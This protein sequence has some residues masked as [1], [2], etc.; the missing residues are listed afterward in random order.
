MGKTAPILVIDNYDSFVHNLVR[1]LRELHVPVVVYRHDALDLEEIAALAP[2]GILLSPGPKRPSDSGICQAAVRAFAGIIP[3]LGVCLG[4]QVIADVFGGSI[5]K[6]KEPVHGKNSQIHHDGR[7]VFTA[8]PMPFSA[9]RYHSLV[10]SDIRFPDCLEV[11]ARTP[12]GIIMGIRHRTLAVE[13]VQFHPEAERTEHGHLLLANFIHQCGFAGEAGNVL[14]QNGQSANPVLIPQ[15]AKSMGLGLHESS[16]AILTDLDD[17]IPYIAETRIQLLSAHV[18]A[19]EVFTATRHMAGTVFLDSAARDPELGRYS[20]VAWSPWMALTERAGGTLRM[21]WDIKVMEPEF[22][23]KAEPHPILEPDPETMLLPEDVLT[24]VAR[25]L[26]ANRKAPYPGLPFVGGAIGL[27]G[28]EAQVQATGILQSEPG[29]DF[30]DALNPCSQIQPATWFWFHRNLFISDHATGLRYL[31][32]TGPDTDMETPESGEAAFWRMMGNTWSIPLDDGCLAVDMAKKP[33]SLSMPIG[34]QE[35]FQTNFTEEAYCDAVSAMRTHISNGDIYL[36]NMTRQFRTKTDLSGFELHDR[37]RRLNP[38]SFSAWFPFGRFELI[39]ASP[40][41]FLRI[42]DGWVETRPIK[43]TRP[44]GTTPE[45]DAANRKALGDSLKDQAELL[46][47]TDLERNDLSLVCEPGTVSVSDL[48]ELEVHPTVFHLA[49][50]VRGRLENGLDAVD[51][52][53][54]CF[55]GG[56]ITGTP[57]I[58]A[59]LV[60][61]ELERIPRGAY[62]GCLGYFGYDGGADFS[63]IIR[64]LVKQGEDVSFGVGGGVTWDSVPSEEHQ[65]TLDKAQA[66]MAVLSEN[67]A[68][69]G[70]PAYH[71][72]Q[73]RSS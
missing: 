68:S 16:T 64:T 42:V 54:A 13:G 33:P 48:F 29:D 40:E 69:S 63:I 58:Q 14:Q 20:M 22:V 32:Q 6:G 39:S 57:K 37:L 52:M 44:R 18:E 43:G 25:V 21:R 61:R 51:C 60:I 67:L 12:D 65:E 11:S 66:L 3:I 38:A 70:E 8:L 17:R 1:Y 47:V 4:H 41:R 45:A 23:R 7:G 72:K 31:L 49:A 50:T 5:V 62:T 10:V 30:T 19:Y 35:R 28:Y 27:I 73:W 24:V 2:S 55:P 53:R 9:T 34:W 36:A 15:Q 59:M 46:M 26:K 56:S 71:A